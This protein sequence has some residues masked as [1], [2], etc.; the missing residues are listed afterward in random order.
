MRLRIFWA[1]DT[2]I[3]CDEA[4][5]DTKNF[6][7]SGRLQGILNFEVLQ[8]EGRGRNERV[9]GIGEEEAIEVEI[10]GGRQNTAALRVRAPVL[11]TLS[12]SRY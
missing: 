12:L 10:V 7:V 4:S 3:V 1:A 2:V 6:I 11:C 8:L 9:L 5:E